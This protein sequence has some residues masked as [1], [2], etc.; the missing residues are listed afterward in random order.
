[1]GR[2]PTV[3][4]EVG[5]QFE[6]LTV[7]EAGL[8]TDGGRRAVK[9]RCTGVP[10][11]EHEPAEKLVQVSALGAVK[12]CGCLN[13]EVAAQRARERNA[14]QPPRLGTGKKGLPPGVKYVKKERPYG[15][16]TNDEGRECAYGGEGNCDR[17]FK[18][19]SEFN[20]G[21]GAR[22]YSS[23]CRD[24]QSV[25]HQ[26][27][28]QADRR[29]YNLEVRLR[30]FGM[31]VEQYRA[32][33]A[34][35]G[36]RCWLCLEFETMTNQDGSPRRLVIDHDHNCCDFDPTPQHPLC[37]KCIR[38]LC[39]MGCNRR[40]LGSVDA[41]GADKVFSYLGTAQAAAQAL[42]AAVS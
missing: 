20:K 36:G 32:M 31:T 24:C 28:P 29:D 7:I 40:V 16:L 1:M 33:E 15:F 3:S 30:A 17:A 21:G 18:P 5:Q 42:L 8:H 26:S 39:C 4:I 12:S 13:R 35:H 37:G 9:V 41:V 23:W 19:W 22:G 34:A 27:R 25:H 10:G 2:K 38:G 11:S 6:R 14:A